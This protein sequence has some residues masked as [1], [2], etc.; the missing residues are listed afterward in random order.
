LKK[1][2]GDNNTDEDAFK[3]LKTRDLTIR[4]GY[5]KLSFAAFY[6]EDIKEVFF[7]LKIL[8]ILLEH[9]MLLR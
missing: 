2:I 9:S 8:H 3:V 6:V 5:N 7:F 4:V 1:Y